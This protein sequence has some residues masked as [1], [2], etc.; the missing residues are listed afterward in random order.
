MTGPP[1]I[2][3]SSDI[4][5]ETYEDSIWDFVTLS[6]E[7]FSHTVENAESLS[8]DNAFASTGSGDGYISYV[9]TDGY[10]IMW[11]RCE[12]DICIRASWN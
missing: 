10:V 5:Y 4:R 11:Q 9:G 1:G 6:H 7:F 2:P 3:A 12:E 8:I